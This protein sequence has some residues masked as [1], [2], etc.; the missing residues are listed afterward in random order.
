MEKSRD[1]AR[2]LFPSLPF[3]WD[4]APALPLEI[5]I[6]LPRGLWVLL[7]TAPRAWCY[8]RASGITKSKA[9]RHSSPFPKPAPAPK[10]LGIGKRKA[11]EGTD[12]LGAGLEE[13]LTRLD[14]SGTGTTP[15]W[16]KPTI[17]PK[18]GT[19]HRP[20]FQQ[21]REPQAPESSPGGKGGTQLQEGPL[22]SPG[23][24]A[25]RKHKPSPGGGS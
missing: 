19:N 5:G 15:H 9:L 11:L 18:D 3:P 10:P 17:A 4:P 7:T 22:C 24:P 20:P 6:S 13:A 16:D 12:V 21:L 14:P 1:K 23:V 25:V 8:R 2:S